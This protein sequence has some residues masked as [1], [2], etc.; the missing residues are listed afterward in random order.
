MTMD[1]LT[2]LT[3]KLDEKAAAYSELDSDYEGR[4]ALSFLSPEAKLALGSRFGQLA[5][6]IPRLAI[7]ALSEQRWVTGLHGADV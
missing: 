7:T 5:S 2:S 6:N 4:Q 3:Q 1:P